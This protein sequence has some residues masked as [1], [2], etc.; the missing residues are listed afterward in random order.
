MD[1]F[2]H[3]GGRGTYGICDGRITS[4]HCALAALQ[5]IANQCTVK[6][7]VVLHVPVFGDDLT[8]PVYEE[9]HGVKIWNRELRNTCHHC[10]TA[11]LSRISPIRV[12]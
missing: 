11:S 7:T 9:V 8:L 5:N 12:R 10:D 1:F 3:D 4:R 2:P 6:F